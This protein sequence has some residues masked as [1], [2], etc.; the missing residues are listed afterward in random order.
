MYGPS[1]K[2][3]LIVDFWQ[4]GWT[5]DEVVRVISVWVITEFLEMNEMAEGE[6][7]EWEGNKS[8]GENSG[9]KQ[10]LKCEYF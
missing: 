5:G 9:D 3:C 8:Q 2:Y 1:W 10:W 6:S 7:E 4:V